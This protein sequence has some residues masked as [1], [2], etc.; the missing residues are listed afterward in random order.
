[1]K[2]SDSERLILT[3]LCEIS[4]PEDERE[5]DPKF[6]LKAILDDA[7]WGIKWKY[8]GLF[9]DKSSD[10]TPPVVSEVMNIL[11]MW[12]RIEAAYKNLSAPDKKRVKAES[13]GEKPAFPG[14]DGNNETEHLGT[15]TFLVDELEKWER[16][17]GR[18]PNSHSPSLDIYK[19]MWAVYKPM[20]AKLDGYMNADQIIAIL[21]A[22][23]HPSHRK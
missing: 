7:A 15:A 16:Y 18:M 9:H 11:D 12:D 23:V 4:L 8:H 13:Y 22:R 3:M 1:M 20:R 19:R 2:L 14:F 5:I 17:K 10:D 6:V 21:K